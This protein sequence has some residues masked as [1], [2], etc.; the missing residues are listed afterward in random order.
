MG[1]ETR[2]LLPCRRKREGMVPPTAPFSL[3][4]ADLFSSGRDELVAHCKSEDCELEMH[5]THLPDAVGH[6]AECCPV[7]SFIL[8]ILG[9][10]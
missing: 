2:S 1:K 9:L 4:S 8:M 5:L 7:W 6:N 3:A 10:G